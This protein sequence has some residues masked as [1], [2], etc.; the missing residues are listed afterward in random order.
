MA[1]GTVD[2]RGLPAPCRAPCGRRGLPARVWHD[3]DAPTGLSLLERVAPIPEQPLSVAARGRRPPCR[4][5]HGLAPAHCSRL[6]RPPFPR[7]ARARDRSHA[8]TAARA[9]AG[10]GPSRDVPLASD[11]GA[12][13][14]RRGPDVGG[15]DRRRRGGPPGL[16]AYV[17]RMGDRVR[18]PVRAR[19]GGI[20]LGASCS[21]AAGGRLFRRLGSSAAPGAPPRAPRA[22][23]GDRRRRAPRAHVRAA[24]GASDGARPGSLDPLPAGGGSGAG[25]P[26]ERR[27]LR[28]P[29]CRARGCPPKA[30]R[31][32]P[33]RR[34]GGR[35][36]SPG[37]R[38][39][40]RRRALR[41]RTTSHPAYRGVCGGRAPR[42]GHGK[43]ERE[44][45]L[46]RGALRPHARG[47]RRSR[48]R[49]IA[50][51]VGPARRGRGPSRPRPRHGPSRRLGLR[52]LGRRATRH[53]QLRCRGEAP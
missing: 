20:R 24:A 6:W 1:R 35:G 50:S 46:P 13:G 16:E 49:G 14:V 31:P 40:G 26:R 53:E 22:S 15:R 25:L 41:R 47:A 51:C 4:R 43:R 48:S 21:R 28:G 52:S 45:Y 2:R 33:P 12:V 19:G 29:L 17:F 18:S 34:L 10:G 42:A 23:R 11:A 32:G 3:A 38:S 5:G 9:A 36:G 39:R 37:C 7:L 30:R 44:P 27:R 8:R